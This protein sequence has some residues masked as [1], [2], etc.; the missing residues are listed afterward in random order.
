M[1]ITPGFWKTH[2]GRKARVLCTD[3]PGN[4]PVIGYIENAAGGS[5][6]CSWNLGGLN[7][8]NDYSTNDLVEPWTSPIAAGHNPDKLTEEQ[9]EVDK[10]WR[11]LSEGEH[12]ANHD[13][14]PAEWWYSPDA[15]WI[16]A[17]GRWICGHGQT[18]RTK[19]PPG[20]FLPKTKKRVPCGPEDFPPGSCFKWSHWREHEYSNVI[21]RNETGIALIVSA[22]GGGTL[23]YSDL[24]KRDGALRSLD[25]G[26]TW[27]PCWKEVD[28]P[29]EAA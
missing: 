10:G 13:V 29:P 22:G 19:M 7:C 12:E 6:L 20:Y 17:E 4:Y 25:G 5:T 23:T 16:G 28:T 1:N 21:Y 18:L 9:V 27:L 14:C 11:L 2:N 8:I 24:F 15:R 26:K 3:A